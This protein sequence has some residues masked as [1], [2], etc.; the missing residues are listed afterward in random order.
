MASVYVRKGKLTMN[1]RYKGIRCRE[2]TNLIDNKANRRRAEQILK[3]IESEIM[4]DQFDYAKYF[5]TSSKLAKV[6]EIERAGSGCYTRSDST[7]RFDKFASQWLSEKQVE[8]RESSYKTV[9]GV[10]KK[11][12]LPVFG[13]RKLSDITKADIL[14]FRTGLAKVPSRKGG[15]LSPSRINHIM[16]PLRV[17]MNEAAER[18]DFT[19][20]WINIKALKVPRTDIEPFNLLEVRQILDDIHPHYHC[21]FLVRFFTA[22]RS[23]EIDGLEW[24]NVDFERRQILISQALVRGK[25]VP[26]KTDGSYRTIHM[27]KPVFDSLLAHKNQVFGRSDYVF[28]TRSGKPVQ[29]RYITRKI[30]Y[31]CLTRCGLSLRTPYQTR[32]TA[33]T[34]WLA[35]GESPEWIANQMGHNSTAMLFKVYSRFIPNLTRQDGS[36]FERLVEREEIGHA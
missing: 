15:T 1:F 21:Y 5:P 9:L 19:S 3:R 18:F 22:M 26:T 31:P 32:H 17:I 25:I 24:R 23:G 7:M 14:N 20:P 27:S 33:A 11:H 12:L 35:A 30:W 8:W 10:L 29:N 13:E 6:R 34:L 28:S 2:Q 4:L 16:T 36:A